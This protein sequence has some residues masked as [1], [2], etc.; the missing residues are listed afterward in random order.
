ML[1]NDSLKEEIAS[2]PKSYQT[3][4]NERSYEIRSQTMSISSEDD[5]FS[6]HSSTAGHPMKKSNSKTHLYSSSEDLLSIEEHERPHRKKDNTLIEK[7]YQNAHVRNFALSNRDYIPVQEDYSKARKKTYSSEDEL[8]DEHNKFKNQSPSPL[9]I[10]SNIPVETYKPQETIISQTKKPMEANVIVEKT[11]QT[12]INIC[13]PHEEMTES[14]NPEIHLVE[15]PMQ[16][17]NETYERNVISPDPGINEVAKKKIVHNIL[18]QL[19]VNQSVVAKH[20]LNG[21]FHE[22]N[23][24]EEDEINVSVKELRK[25]FENNDVSCSSLKSMFSP[26]I[27]ETDKITIIMKYFKF[28]KRL[29]HIVIKLKH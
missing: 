6:E 4:T 5:V 27:K 18:E 12:F 14:Q 17:A 28:R 29:D 7:I 15:D 3:S 20:K 25:K 26:L 24:N 10:N 19:S 2:Q 16:D 23:N 1:E 22:I 9:P 21:D 11:L 13:P 8:S